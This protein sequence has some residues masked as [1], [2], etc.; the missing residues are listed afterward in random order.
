MSYCAQMY[1]GDGEYNAVA[2][3]WFQTPEASVRS[4]FH[5]PP[6]MLC[7]SFGLTLKHLVY[8]CM[9]VYVLWSVYMLSRLFQKSSKSIEHSPS[10]KLIVTWLVKNF[11][12]F[13]GKTVSDF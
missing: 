10:E 1:C 6:G 9:P 11:L 4:L 12:A 3:I 8:F 2:A 13:Y 7:W 5:D